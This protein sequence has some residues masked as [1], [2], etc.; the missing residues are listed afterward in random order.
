MTARLK[1]SFKKELNNFI[2]DDRTF[3]GI[4]ILI[5]ISVAV[6]VIESI[7]PEGNTNTT[8][9]IISAF[10]TTIFVIELIIRW[11]VA[12]KFGEFVKDCWIEILAVFP[13]S[14][15]FRMLRLMRL[16]RLV[17]WG[18]RARR[19][20]RFQSFGSI[21][22]EN[23][24][25]IVVPV[26]VVI[27]STT[28]IISFEANQ[29]T[30]SSPLN[31]FFW[32]FSTLMAGEPIYGEPATTGGKVV[33]TILMLSG[34]TFFAF[35]TGIVSSYMTKRLRD[36]IA[37][38]PTLLSKLEDHII[39]CG[40]NGAAPEIIKELRSSKGT[41]KRDII[42]VSD[43]KPL[44]DYKREM[45]NGEILFVTDDYTAGETLERVRVDKAKGVV[46]LAGQCKTRSSQD[47][48]ARTVLAALTAEKIA[49]H[50]GENESLENLYCFAELLEK[51]ESKC[52]V[53]AEAKV[54][55]KLEANEFLGHLIAHS[56]AVEGLNHILDNLMTSSYGT[57]FQLI[58]GRQRKEIESNSQEYCFEEL[59]CGYKGDAS[60]GGITNS[61][62][63]DSTHCS[64][65]SKNVV[66]A[67]N[68]N[69]YSG[70]IV[71]GYRCSIN[72]DIII[73][74]GPKERIPL[75][76]DLLVIAPLASH[77]IENRK[78][79]QNMLPTQEQDQA[80]GCNE[81]GHI[82][83]C[84]WNRSVPH[85]IKE[86]KLDK[87][88]NDQKINIILDSWEVPE[89]L[90]N[91]EKSNVFKTVRGD[92]TSPQVLKDAEI[93]KAS[94]V[95][96]VAD[97]LSLKR[98]TQDKDA[99]SVLAALTIEKVLKKHASSTRIFVELLNVNKRK[100]KNSKEADDHKVELL[101]GKVEMVA[102]SDIY[103]GH[104]IAQSIKAPGLATVLY[105]LLTSEQGCKFSKETFKGAS[106]DF[107]KVLT[108][109]Q[110]KK[111]KLVVGFRS[112]NGKE[113]QYTANPPS[114]TQINHGDEL[115]YIFDPK[116][117]N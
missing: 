83:I 21:L 38:D 75:D 73:N 91:L 87:E 89:E 11:Y 5:L 98:T 70:S 41:K 108:N 15:T 56:V 66:K 105:E 31:S 100:D 86:L 101:K 24:A 10:L 106:T 32:S 71:V 64:F 6:T 7:V 44:F 9:D 113:F 2:K 14:R 61:F 81:I 117:C 107:H 48:D 17:S 62:F 78:V 90:E 54:E 35:F 51:N 20:H 52:E 99:R 76:A 4:L 13:V 50:K 33:T 22:S 27:G 94:N 36:D 12:D 74:P 116:L 92:F 16:M 109:Y 97:S 57:E 88:N 112:L 23:I 85:I 115:Y 18:F 79:Q 58:E 65:F 55:E 111:N 40:W 39:I 103:L 47:H 93:A 114:E 25:L 69:E 80:L 72:Q 43:E 60:G 59:V 67:S 8:C 82:V 1:G 102:S 28:A 46:F 3:I 19:Q 29:G 30:F 84:G 110:T 26:V 96:I 95:I 68:T 42:V 77:Q 63:K 34:F 45:N 53:L 104:L 37:V 49:L